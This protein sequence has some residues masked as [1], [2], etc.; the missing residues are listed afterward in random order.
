MNRRYAGPV[1]ET[2]GTSI[3]RGATPGLRWLRR[4]GH[5]DDVETILD[6]GAGAYDRNG[7]WLRKQGFQVYS[8]DPYNGT[9]AD[10]WERVSSRH[11]VCRFDLVLTSYVLCVVPEHTSLEIIQRVTAKGGKSF[12]IVRNR[13]MIDMVRKAL[14]KGNNT[15]TEFFLEEFATDEEER[16]YVTGDLTDDII[17]DFCLFGTQTTKGFQRLVKGEDYGL[18]LLYDTKSY[19]IYGG[20][21]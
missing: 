21:T 7:S 9:Y 19:K 1:L 18:R 16:L 5:L 15:V 20:S 13:D 14:N 3:N 6:Y 10:G 8:Y 4:K 17:I 12:H 2:G 11:P